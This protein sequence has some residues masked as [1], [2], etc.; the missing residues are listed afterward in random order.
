MKNLIPAE[1]I[2]SVIKP[3]MINTSPEMRRRLTRDENL[4]KVVPEN[5]E[6]FR[7]L[8]REFNNED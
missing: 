4:L 8:F 2:F 5:M 7:R 1:M 6:Y 3:K